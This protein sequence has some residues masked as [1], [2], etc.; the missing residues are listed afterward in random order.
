MGNNTLASLFLPIE[1]WPPHPMNQEIYDFI[2][3]DKKCFPHGK[4]LVK[5]G[6]KLDQ[7]TPL[8]QNDIK[9]EAKMDTQMNIKYK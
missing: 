7:I 2:D 1:S 4:N 6:K 3:D 8:I 9:T 5:W